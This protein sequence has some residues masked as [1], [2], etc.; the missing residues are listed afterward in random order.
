M[1]QEANKGPVYLQDQYSPCRV[2]SNI[3]RG[4]REESDLSPEI[5]KIALYVQVDI[6]MCVLVVR[7]QESSFQLFSEKKKTS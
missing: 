5:S 2:D 6:R 3:K 4:V 7:R 1:F